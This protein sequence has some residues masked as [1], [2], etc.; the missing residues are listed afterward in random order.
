[1]RNRAGL[2]TVKGLVDSLGGFI[3]VACTGPGSGSVYRMIL[4]LKDI[5]V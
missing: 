3:D 1:M 2:P 5:V 4:P